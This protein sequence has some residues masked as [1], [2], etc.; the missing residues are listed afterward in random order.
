MKYNEAIFLRPIL[1]HIELDRLKEQ[2]PF[3]GSEAVR[4]Q[5]GRAEQ[6][7]A[8]SKGSSNL[9]SNNF[10]QDG[11]GAAGRASTVRGPGPCRGALPPGCCC[12]ALGF[13]LGLVPGRL[14][15]TWFSAQPTVP[16]KVSTDDEGKAAALIQN[17]LIFVTWPR[18][19]LVWARCSRPSF[20]AEWW[21]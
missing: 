1:H 14:E 11:L 12:I 8:W 5:G 7:N 20:V 18:F 16:T 6:S 3:R 9:V 13:G 19:E 17:C 4:H 2:Q 15:L 10:P 21:A